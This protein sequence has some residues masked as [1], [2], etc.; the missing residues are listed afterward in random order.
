MNCGRCGRE[1]ESDSAFCR[2]C[3]ATHQESGTQRRLFRLP[4]QGR[5]AGVC[6]GIADYFQADVTLIRLAWV[7]VSIVPGFLVGGVIAYI[8]AWLIMP[9]SAVPATGRGRHAR[10]TRSPVDR[11]LG[12]VCGGIAEYIGLDSTIV[13]LAWIILTIVPGAIV[14]GVVVYLVAWFIMPE[15]PAAPLVATPHTA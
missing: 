14:L 13:R 9:E 15:G 10:L 1:L 8:A 6:A 2:H 5:I 4:S 11:K 7:V 3:G 12:G